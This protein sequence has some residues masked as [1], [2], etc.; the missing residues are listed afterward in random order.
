MLDLEFIRQNTQV[1]RTNNARRNSKVSVDEVLDLD[2]RNRDLITQTEDLR[3]KQNSI[4]TEIAGANPD[5]RQTL[6]KESSSL[7]QEI[8]ALESDSEPIRVKLNELLMQLPNIAHDSVP[9]GDNE[10][11]NVVVKTWGVK[12]EF[13]FEPKDHVELMTNLGM[14]D[15]ERGTKVHGFRGYFLKGDGARLS[16]AIWNYARDFYSKLGFEEFFAPT[17]LREKFFYATGHLPTEAEDLYQTQ[18]DDY[19]SGTAEVPMMAYYSDEILNLDQLPFKALAFS[20][21]YRREAGSYSKDTKGLIR[22][23][24]FQKL[25]QVVLCEADDKKVEK[26][27]EEINGYF[28]SFLE[29][30]QLP[31]QRLNICL[32]DLSKSKVKQYDVE[33]WFPSQNQ[34]RELSSASYFNDFQTRRF[35]IRYKDSKTGENKFAY[36]LNNTAAATPRLLVALIENFQQ[37]DGSITIPEVLVP[38]F[39]KKTIAISNEKN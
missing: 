22:V 20:P 34:Y 31:Y 35:N 16:W 18:D 32:G 23:H 27:H 9:D 10:N 12:P 29:S 15:F 33:A 26:F 7:K 13:N 6:I 25:E 38:Y 39:G 2:K 5:R 30:M 1:I 19:L 8:K 11:N 36:S 17:I 21:C 4:S 24:E 3:A 37:A 28:E 14:V